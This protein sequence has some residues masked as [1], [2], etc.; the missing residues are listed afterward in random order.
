M[1]NFGGIITRMLVPDRDGKLA[2]VV[3][4][5]N[6]L[7]DYVAPHPYFGA[8]V[9]RVAGRTTGAQF[10]LDEQAYPLVKNDG[11]NHLH[12]GIEGFDKKLWT[13]ECVTDEHGQA[14]LRLCYVSPDGEE[15]YPGNLKMFVT[16]TFTDDNALIIDS[17]CSTDRAT[18]VVLTNHSYFN[19][20]GEG[21]G[22]IHDH[23][24][25]VRG[26]IC[27]LNDGRM[28][29]LGKAVPV[30]GGANDFN[31]PRRI[32]EVLPQLH[33]QHGAHYFLRE[34]SVNE[35]ASHPLVHVAK[36]I[37]SETGRVLDV[38]TTEECLQF[39]TGVSLDGT[40]VGKSGRAYG[41]HAGLCL[42]C[43]AYPD[44][45]NVPALGS[46]I[47]RPGNVLRHTT[48]YAFSTQ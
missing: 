30:A 10:V 9:G 40:L 32:G 35:A 5:F 17:E 37:H 28:T 12:G 24:L 19:L 29:L 7:E 1:T 44:G 34:P 18:P 4:G 22:T 36:V 33:M 26:D 15:G 46:N 48:I 43:E 39:Y 13:A 8:I 6:R 16:Y 23:V 47:L 38:S 3:L 31:E 45:A 2:D 25:Q 21:E 42:E 11:E 41:P 27:A 14:S 20:A